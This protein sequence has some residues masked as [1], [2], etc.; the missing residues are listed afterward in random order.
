MCHRPVTAAVLDKLKS[1][2]FRCKILHL[3]ATPFILTRQFHKTYCSNAFNFYS[4]FSRAV[5]LYEP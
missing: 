4:R 2:A 1:L 3:N 5:A